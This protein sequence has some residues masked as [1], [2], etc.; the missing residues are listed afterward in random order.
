MQPS[1]ALFDARPDIVVGVHVWVALATW[2]GVCADHATTFARQIILR[3]STGNVA[4][5]AL[6]TQ[7]IVDRGVEVVDTGIEHRVEDG[8]GLC[9]C[10]V[11]STWGATQFHGP[12][13]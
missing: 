6:L 2:S 7:A 4:A 3:P 1:E 5:D 11:A 9:L 8:F 12:I 10:H 13:A